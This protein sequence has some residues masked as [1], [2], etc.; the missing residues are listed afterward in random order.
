MVKIL[1]KCEDD[2]SKPIWY[3][4]WEGEK[5][6]VLDALVE[7]KNKSYYPDRLELVVVEEINGNLGGAVGHPWNE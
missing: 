1:G 7:L 2:Y 3:V 6:K 5:D 4:V